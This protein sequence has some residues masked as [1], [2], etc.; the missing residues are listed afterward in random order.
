M[1]K[2]IHSI[3][4]YQGERYEVMLSIPK[5]AYGVQWYFAKD[6]V[7]SRGIV[8]YEEGMS[9]CC[10]RN[11]EVKNH[12]GELFCCDYTLRGMQHHE[13]AL[14]LSKDTLTMIRKNHFDVVS[15]YDKTS[16]HLVHEAEYRYRYED[17]I[18][19]GDELI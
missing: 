17:G 8:M 19:I 10:L 11:K 13:V 5:E 15:F 3:K 18:D 12:E 16:G 7:K 2:Y 6:V 9:T 14:Y 1:K 4:T